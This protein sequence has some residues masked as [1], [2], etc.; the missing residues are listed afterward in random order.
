MEDED[1]DK[2]VENLDKEGLK[3]SLINNW[4]QV[5]LKNNNRIEFNII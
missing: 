1:Q 5:K 2:D 3:K 4:Y